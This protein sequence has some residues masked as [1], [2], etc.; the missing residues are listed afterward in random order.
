MIFA[1]RLPVKLT[2]L[3]T[4][5][6]SYGLS[7]F[8]GLSMVVCVFVG[9]NYEREFRSNL[10]QGFQQ[11][12]E[13]GDLASSVQQL[14]RT[15]DAPRA[16]DP[17]FIGSLIERT[18]EVESKAKAQ[19]DAGRVADLVLPVK[20]LAAIAAMQSGFER[21]SASTAQVE[22]A[23][24]LKSSLKPSESADAPTLKR[25]SALID[26]YVGA[27]G[28]LR[29]ARSASAA[30]PGMTSASMS[31]AENLAGASAESR[32][33]TVNPAWREVLAALPIDRGDLVDRL[34]AD[35][36][37]LEDFQT[38]RSRALSRLEQ[39]SAKI[40]SA[41]RMLLQSR[42]GGG[43]L[44]V[45]SILTW[46]GVGLGLLAIALTWVQLRQQT[47]VSPHPAAP[48][49]LV[50]PH[51]GLPADGAPHGQPSV[52]ANGYAIEARIA[53]RIASEVST[54]VS[55]RELA[56]AA[57]E[58][59]IDHVASG[60][61]IEAGS[62]AER[63][64]ALLD[65]QSEQLE[66]H[67]RAVLAAVE[68]LAGRADMVVQSLQLVSEE[69]APHASM[70]AAVL[71]KR[72]EELQ[73]LAMNLSL[74]VRSG[75]SSDPLL[76]DLE[77]FNAN[78]GSLAEDIR[79]V[80]KAGGVAQIERRLSHSIEEGRRMVAASDSLKERT[81]TLFEDVQRF[82]RHSEA[83]IRGIQEGAVAELPASYIRQR[84]SV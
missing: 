40:D 10:E 52:D 77:A 1:K 6:S 42:S 21:L 46:V 74:Q 16:L 12:V 83:L 59:P 37:M 26:D 68:T 17:G 32:K 82:R 44:V 64:V 18:K 84:N 60:Y 63:R 36:R 33:K 2:T 61:W 7:A 50:V 72:T 41:E 43:L 8:F 5:M 20:E 75:E 28:A 79:R 55:V 14:R 66:Q 35:A 48:V 23:F 65:K 15:L 57:V 29:N 47:E 53:A 25:V 51:D 58:D 56:E 30:L 69:D 78:L 31:L 73:A 71:R 13:L 22:R 80:S 81:E 70:D 9:A 62:M 4:W 39:V 54:A 67:V 38:Q 76:D 34:L 45:S 19:N 24:N 27:A 11:R 49:G 3:S